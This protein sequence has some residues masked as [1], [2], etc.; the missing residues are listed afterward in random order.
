MEDKY[1]NDFDEM[2]LNIRTSFRLLYHFNRRILDLMKFISNKLS[3]PYIGGWSKYSN[4]S[5][6]YG[7]G[8]L[9]SWAWDWLNLYFYEFHF[10]KD[11][12]KFSVFLQCDTGSWDTEVSPL[13]VDKYGK[14]SAAKS[15]LVFVLSNSGYW[16]MEAFLNDEYWRNDSENE[17]IISG[18]KKD[19]KMVCK[20]FNIN[21][22]QNEAMAKESLNN[23]IKYIKRNGINELNII[24]DI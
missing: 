1:M 10:I 11:K 5:P 17:F 14:I 8:S 20:A 12:I 2:L 3:V 19:E 4:T 22:F 7:K 18:E 6:G 9:D 15:R 16:D 23:F 24:E 13:N 21:E